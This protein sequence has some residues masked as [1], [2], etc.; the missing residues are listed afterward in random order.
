[1]TADPVSAV[2]QADLLAVPAARGAC[3]F[4]PP[5]AYQQAR[6]SAPVSPARQWDGAPLWLVTGYREVR[7]VLADQRF[8]ADPRKPGFPFLSEGRRELVPENNETFIRMDDPE[9]ARLRRMLTGEFMLKRIE[10]LRPKVQELADGLIDRMSA[11][12]RREADLVAEF[13]LPLPSLVICLMLGVPYQDHAFFQTHSRTLLDNSAAPGVLRES[14]DA[15]I[16]YMR[17]LAEEKR[18]TPDG[19]IV[20]R[21]I[22]RGDLTPRQVASMSL[23]LLIAGHETTANMTS[24]SVLALLRNPPQLARLRAEPELLRGAVEELL[25]YLSIVQL[26][27]TRAA[28]EDVTVG[29][30]LIRAGE[31]VLCMLNAANRDEEIFPG[32]DE[33]DVGRSARGHVAFGFGVHQCLGQPLARLELQIALDRLLD[34]LPGLRLDLPFDEVR[35]RHE[36]VVYGVREL[37]VAW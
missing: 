14:R 31:G 17:D 37:P 16:G 1:M 10:E 4:D 15:L 20:S 8:S 13:A 2:H 21:L 22:E 29:G 24:L 3:P 23:L 35:Y 36:M 32:A 28:T 12:G 18:R 6:R 26:G 19:G 7:E 5:P 33:L 11:N 30:Q 34:R 25:R 9:H 27:I